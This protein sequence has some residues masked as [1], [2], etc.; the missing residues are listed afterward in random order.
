VLEWDWFAYACGQGPRLRRVLRA[1]LEERTDNTLP[2]HSIPTLTERIHY[3]S[4]LIYQ[5]EQQ[6]QHLRAT[7]S[8][9][10]S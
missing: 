3:L 2:D 6:M 10:T 7:V 5:E 1:Q 9:P 4:S 8:P